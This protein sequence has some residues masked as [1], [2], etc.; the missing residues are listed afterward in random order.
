ML[1][2]DDGAAQPG[3]ALAISQPAHALVSGQ[4]LAAWGRPLD[5]RVVLAAG[6]HDVAWLDWEVAPSFDPQ[7]R[8]PREFRTIG[9]AEHAPM[10]ERG[11]ER[12]LAAWGRR[13]ALL[14]SRHG[15]T[16]YRRFSDRHRSAGGPG[17]AADEAAARDYLSRHQRLQDDWA[18]ALG[19][20]AD[21]VAHDADL[22]AF[23]D[24]LSLV[25]CGALPASSR[26]D[27]GQQ[28]IMLSAHPDGT[29]GLDPWPF[30][31]DRLSVEIEARPLPASGRFADA[32][33]MQ[34][35]LADPARTML[36]RRL[37][38]R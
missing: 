21:A 22:I 29:F 5:E 24:T 1:F 36:R 35:W 38:R 11:V 26:L 16:I 10:W 13:V 23:A 30:A 32:A 20:D 8:R 3:A 17:L 37:V 31:V 33:A 34:G 9:A 15:S 25:L 14:V 28:P 18:G 27:I 4:L 12:A 2:S 6:Q 7:T 19:L